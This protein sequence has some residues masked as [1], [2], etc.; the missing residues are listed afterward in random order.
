MIKRA[1]SNPISLD[2]VGHGGS[3]YY[4]Y[5]QGD[6]DLG[7]ALQTASGSAQGA[8]RQGIINKV[9]ADAKRLVENFKILKDTYDPPENKASLTNLGLFVQQNK[10]ILAGA[11]AL[12][13]GY[14]ILKG[15]KRKRRR[16]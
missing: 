4:H 3:Q 6:E 10:V 13:V 7:S 5:L 8:L 9:I 15:K 11:L 2:G 12:G 16:R 14:Y 1:K